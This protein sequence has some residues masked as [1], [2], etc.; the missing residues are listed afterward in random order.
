MLVLCIGTATEVGKTWVGAATLAALRA[1][2]VTVS[3]RKP[4]QSHDPTDGLPL[5]S[6]LLA[7]ATGERPVEVCAVERTYEVAMAPPMAAAVL[8]RPD[9]SLGE[10]LGE[11][12]WPVPPPQVRW[13][14]TVGGPRSP[15]AADGD[16]VDLARRVEP[17]LVVLV[18]DAGLGTINAVL[19]SVAPFGDL[20]L[21][22]T[23]VANRYDR[24]DDLHQR[25]VAWLRAR[26]LHVLTGAAEL[27]EELAAAAAPA[28]DR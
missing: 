15:L 4:A 12:R 28:T 9:P 26:G 10:L 11:L 1:R 16:S 20:A 27:A 19:L 8:G 21:P 24:G 22:V 17:D 23:V 5:D 2:G 14:E 13:I 25:N 18:A 7:A 3:A 6:E